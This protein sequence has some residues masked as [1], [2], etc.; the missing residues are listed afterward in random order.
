MDAVEMPVPVGL[1]SALG[2][3]VAEMCGGKEAGTLSATVVW[4][5]PGTGLLASACPGPTVSMG[6][7]GPIGLGPGPKIRP[8]QL[9]LGIYTV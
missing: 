6:T 2:S 9:A 8:P 7:P 5:W 1:S 3:V 4:G